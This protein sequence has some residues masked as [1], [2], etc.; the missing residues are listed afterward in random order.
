MFKVTIEAPGYRAEMTF[1]DER[2]M[3]AFLKSILKTIQQDINVNIEQD[4]S[5]SGNA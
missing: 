4:G 3:N 5:E 1:K 2:K